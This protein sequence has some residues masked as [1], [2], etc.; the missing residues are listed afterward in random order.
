M[1][2]IKEVRSKDVGRPKTER[3]EER[4]ETLPF[5]VV[6]LSEEGRP[7]F[8][9]RLA[10]KLLPPPSRLGRFLE[11]A[12]EGAKEKVILTA[13]L[14]GVSYFVGLTRW[15]EYT[16]LSFLETLLPLHPVF[17]RA[18]LERARELFPEFDRAAARLLEKRTGGKEEKEHL[19]RISAR[20]RRLR[21]EEGSYL[22]LM[23][24]SERSWDEPTSCSLDGFLRVLTGAMQKARVTL[25]VSCP[26]SAGVWVSPAVLGFVMVNLLHFIV[27]FEGEDRI[28][29]SVE[30]GEKESV[31]ELCFP[32]REGLFSLYGTLTR[33]GGETVFPQALA[34]APL[35]CAM[36]VCR[37]CGLSL[38]LFRREEKGILRLTLPG[39]FRMPEAFLGARDARDDAA[40]A[41][42]V[43]EIFLDFVDTDPDIKGI[44]P[45]KK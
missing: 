18:L 45:E 5:P 30:A 6:A 32:D 15:S 2:E 27:L 41:Q 9:N 31:I 33:T 3:M 43:R 44:S 8:R 42:W 34:F 24:L 39:S 21:E 29:V 37:E 1:E 23:R 36:T 17:S 20:I 35:F 40:M 28:D 14:E 26:S 38:Y 10:K 16:V 7:V 13:T 4:L 11:W 25:F 12:W 19:D 22:R